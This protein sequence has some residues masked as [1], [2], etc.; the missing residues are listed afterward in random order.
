MLTVCEQR[1]NTDVKTSLRENKRAA[2]SKQTCGG[3]FD[4]Y[5]A[6]KHVLYIHRSTDTCA[7]MK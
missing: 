7:G 1:Q 6:R 5:F 4:N 2:K 3:K